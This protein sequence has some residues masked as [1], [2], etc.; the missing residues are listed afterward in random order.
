[1]EESE[2]KLHMYEEL[3]KGFVRPK[4]DEILEKVMKR[5]RGISG[6]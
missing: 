3:K 5:T 1:M 4:P 2:M 6:L